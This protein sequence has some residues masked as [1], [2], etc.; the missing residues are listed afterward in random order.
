MQSSNEF[1]EYWRFI[2]W[3]FSY[4]METF[5]SPVWKRSL[6]SYG[7]FVSC[8]AIGQEVFTIVKHVGPDFSTVC[9]T[10]H[11]WTHWEGIVVSEK[12]NKFII[13]VGWGNTMTFFLVELMLTFTPRCCNS[14]NRCFLQCGL[15]VMSLRWLDMFRNGISYCNIIIK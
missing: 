8:C 12:C 2:L 7:E 11:I 13:L 9:P 5:K 1:C 10:V 4:R 15:Q 6:L 14:G 3:M